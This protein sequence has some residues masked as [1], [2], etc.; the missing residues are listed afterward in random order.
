RWILGVVPK[1]SHPPELTELLLPRRLKLRNDDVEQYS[2]C[3]R[4]SGTESLS[5]QNRSECQ[6]SGVVRQRERSRCVDVANCCGRTQMID[7]L[8]ELGVGEFAIGDDAG[9]PSLREQGVDLTAS[10][11]P[12]CG[13]ERTPTSSAAM[14]RSLRVLTNRSSPRRQTSGA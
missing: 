13:H 11:L 4:T 3:A 14:G 2:M 12:S 8:R 10:A 1:A 7:C 6:A 5:D 9:E